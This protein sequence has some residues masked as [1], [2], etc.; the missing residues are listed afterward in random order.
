MLCRWLKTLIKT[1]EMENNRLEL[2]LRRVEFSVPNDKMVFEKHSYNGVLGSQGVDVYYKYLDDL[3]TSYFIELRS[4]I[5]NLVTNQNSQLNNFINSKLLLFN[6][7]KDDFSLKNYLDYNSLISNYEQEIKVGNNNPNLKNEYY[8]VK[9]YAEMSSIQLSFIE[10]AIDELQQLYNNYNQQN[11]I[12]DT[13]TKNLSTINNSVSEY[14]D[15]YFSRYSEK[16]TLENKDLAFIFNITRPT[17]DEWKEQGKFIEISD[18]G[19]RPILYSKEDVKNSIKNGI[20]PQRLVDI[21]N[22]NF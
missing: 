10:K 22:L 19:K 16:D 20:L 21:K 4:N 6:D 9:F 15:D 7:I 12:V 14:I 1:S 18:K 3:Y 5:D 8:T 11:D 17:I 2:E 13:S